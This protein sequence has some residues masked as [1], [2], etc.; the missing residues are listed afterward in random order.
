LIKAGSAKLIK[1][2]TDVDE[3]GDAGDAAWVWDDRCG[4][5]TANYQE[6]SSGLA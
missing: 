4:G 2:S 1:S 5:A 3:D 6:G